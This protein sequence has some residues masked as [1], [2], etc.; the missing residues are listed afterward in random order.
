MYVAI[1]LLTAMKEARPIYS[2]S[3]DGSVS[4]DPLAVARRV[5]ITDSGLCHHRNLDTLH[6]MFCVG[7]TIPTA[8]YAKKIHKCSIASYICI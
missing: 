8:I 5:I 1:Q 7:H 6:Y 3:Y 4:D 2:M